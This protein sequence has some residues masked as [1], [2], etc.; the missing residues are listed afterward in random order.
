MK[1]FLGLFVLIVSVGFA[2]SS[3]ATPPV[4]YSYPQHGRTNNATLAIKDFEAVG[5]IFCKSTEVIDSSGTHTGSK[6]TYEMIMLEAQK[7][8]ASDVINIKIDVNQV[9]TIARDNTGT[10]IKKVT[11]NYT[12]SALAI[13][14]T[15]AIAVENHFSNSQDMSKAMNLE[16][17]AGAPKSN[18]GKTVGIVLGG[19]LGV[20]ALV[21]G[22]SVL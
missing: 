8:G 15:N 21:F 19:V 4:N 9:E 12:A 2:F 10:E 18:K 20:I 1:K 13:K 14:Y 5:I 7:L 22:I 17:D 11:L 16:D 3:C 6:I